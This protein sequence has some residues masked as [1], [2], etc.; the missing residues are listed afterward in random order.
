M[1]PLSSLK[2]LSL[3]GSHMPLNMERTTQLF[4]DLFGVS[5]SEGFLVNMTTRCAESLSGFNENLKSRLI[6]AQVL[7]NDETGININGTLHWIHTAGN[8]EY[9]YLFP[10]RKEALMLLMKQVWATQMIALLLEIKDKVDFCTVRS[11]I[12]TARKRGKN[13]LEVLAD[14]FRT[15]YA[16]LRYFSEDNILAGKM[17]RPSYIHMVC[18]IGFRGFSPYLYTFDIAA[19]D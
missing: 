2:R 7:H 11:Y 1:S 16:F 18:A 8:S 13:I 15:L 6:G 4:K 12:S 5:L 10:L 17:E 14:A 19:S 9:T 3:K